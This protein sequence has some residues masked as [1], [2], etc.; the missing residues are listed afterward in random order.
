L[1]RRVRNPREHADYSGGLGVLAGDHLKSA[2]D[3]GIPLVG[4]GLMYRQGYFEQQLTQDGQQLSIYPSY[5]FHRC[6]AALA[7]DPSGAPVRISVQLGSTPL[8]AQVWLVRVGRVRLFLLDTDIAENSPE[9]RQI[10]YRLYGGEQ[11]MRIRQEI[12]L[13]IGGLRALKAL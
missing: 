7:A 4:I 8:H 13:G 5:D 3:L 2:S 6:P 9:L 1:F 11:E 12:L 10:T